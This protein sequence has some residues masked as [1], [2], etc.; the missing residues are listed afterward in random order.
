MLKIFFNTLYAVTNSRRS[1]AVTAEG[2]ADVLRI[3]YQKYQIHQIYLMYLYICF[4]KYIR[5][6]CLFS[7][8]RDFI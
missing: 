5:F 7:I 6:I 2:V 3:K 4:I 1:A 8:C